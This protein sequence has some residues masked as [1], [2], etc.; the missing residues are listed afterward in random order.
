MKNYI[1]QL[2]INL[3]KWVTE[4]LLSKVIIPIVLT[5]IYIVVLGPTSIIA[6][7]F[8]KAHLTKRSLHLDTNW[9]DNVNEIP[10]LEELK[11]QS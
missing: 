4:F 10:T 5:L 6:K 8:F 2:H 9:I 11:K 7:I 1:K 3:K